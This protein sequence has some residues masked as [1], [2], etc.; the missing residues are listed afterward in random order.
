MA[1]ADE[2][3]SVGARQDAD[4]SRLDLV[5]QQL[6]A[7]ATQDD[8][9]AVFL[10][11]TQQIADSD[12]RVPIAEINVNLSDLS[13]QL[14]GLSLRAAQTEEAFTG[15]ATVDQIAALQVQVD[16]L[17]DG[18]LP[19]M[20]QLDAISTQ[21]EALWTSTNELRSQVVMLTSFVCTHF[22]ADELAQSSMSGLCL[23]NPSN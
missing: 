14:Q 21:V 10:T 15:V 17:S 20:S 4:G 5:E 2:V 13:D 22:S 9:L 6:T 23:G 11:L 7:T 3:D 18:M 19:V 16:A 1:L 8:L 12:M